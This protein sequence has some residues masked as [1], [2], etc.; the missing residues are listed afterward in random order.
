[1]TDFELPRQTH[2][3]EDGMLVELIS[4]GHSD[5]PFTCVHSYLVVIKP[6]C[7]RAMHYHK[8]K[9]EWIAHTSGNINIVLEDLK[10][11]KK[12]DISMDETMDKYSLIHIPPM[13]A[14]VIKNVGSSNASIVVFSKSPM[15]QGDTIPY[16]MEI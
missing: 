9:E 13:V 11:N 15:I 14:H 5:V 10:N 12:K 8:T 6:G 7:F 2:V 1:M 3:R 16:R 4:M